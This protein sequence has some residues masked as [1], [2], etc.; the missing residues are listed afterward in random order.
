MKILFGILDNYTDITDICNQKCLFN[1]YYIIPELDIYRPAIFGDPLHGILKHIKF[2]A[3]NGNTKIFNEGE[4]INVKEDTEIFHSMLSIKNVTYMYNNLYEYERNIPIEY[5]NKLEKYEIKRKE[6]LDFNYMENIIKKEL[7]C[8]TMF[9][10]LF[11]RCEY[12]YIYTR[13]IALDILLN[14]SFS[15]KCLKTGNIY[16]SSKCFQYLV[17]NN[18]DSAGSYD[19]LNIYVF[20][21]IENPFFVAL[22]NG[23]MHMVL[24]TNIHFIYYYKCN[25]IFNINEYNHWELNKSI[26]CSS[27]LDYYNNNIIIETKKIVSTYGYANNIGHSYW[28]DVSGLYFIYEMNLLKN[29][30]LFLI[31]NY[32]YYNLYNFLKKNNYNVIYENNLEKINIHTNNEYLFIKYNDLIMFDGL[33]T[34][35]LNNLN[36]I[37]INEKD[38][39][40][41][42]KKK[43]FPIITFNI[44]GVFRGLHDQSEKISN[45]INN[46]YKLYPN[47]YILFDGYIKNKNV[48][49]SIYRSEGVNSSE[50][51]FD[52]S[53]NNIINE[54]ISKLDNKNIY[55][56]LIGLNLEDQLNWLDISNYGLMQL[57]AGAF[58]YI[59][60]MNKKGIFIGRN[61]Y[62][63]DAVLNHTFHDFIFREK[64]DF[65]TYINPKIVKFDGFPN[66]SF[67]I[68][69]R[70]I[71]YYM[72]RD[73]IIIEKNNFKLLQYENVSKYDIYQD[74]G[75]NI[76]INTLI[77]NNIIDSKNILENFINNNF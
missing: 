73:L 50:E 14:K 37:N 47:I 61:A 5:K 21:N 32:D 34:F 6:L 25:E 40:S 66:N 59:W 7:F 48:D 55:K 77:N 54:I 13:E 65:T 30:D 72:L 44:R 39:I 64:R 20:D 35:I 9:H 26:I 41:N 74:W 28:N 19:D 8:K 49:L 4:I 10:D 45:I 27:I 3:N 63:N 53:Y 69:W 67:D 36:D 11:D 57:G 33:K 62:F 70:I 15:F 46:L 16:R 76:D 17:K 71:F 75:L 29:I 60:L 1:G 24:H 23:S 68:D 51:I 42:I 43:H 38:K 18:I 56:S 58:N 12:T 31:G 52:N 22:G 2:I